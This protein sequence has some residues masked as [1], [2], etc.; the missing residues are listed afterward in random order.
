MNNAFV[1]KARLFAGAGV[2]ALSLAAF[3][4]PAYAQDA[5]DDS[6]QA[7]A[8][9][10]VQETPATAERDTIVVTGS[11]IRRDEYST[12]EPIT[13]VTA[14][15]ITQSG[16]NSA[17]DALQSAE[18]TAGSGQI[19]NY[20]AGFVT[21]G[22][23]GANTL[24]LRGLGPARTLV[25][26]NGRRLAPA[27][28][29]GAV[30][31]ADL[32]VLPTAIVERIE[33]LKAGASSVYGSDAIAGVVNII[34]DQEVRGLTLD[35]Q[36]NV[37]E[38]GSG[39]DRRISATFGLGTDRLNLIGSLEYRKRN[40][41]RLADADFTQ[42]PIP[43]NIDGEGAPLGSADPYPLGDPRNCFTIDNGGVTI[44]TIGTGS[45]SGI[46][47]TSGALGTFNRFVPAPGQGG[48]ATP[49]YLGVG[50]YDRDSFDPASQQEYLITPVETYTGYLSGTYELDAL[51]NAEL[52]AE[53]LATRRKSEAPLYRQLS[54]DYPV[55]LVD[56]RCD[57]VSCSIDPA[58]PNPLVPE[59]L[60]NSILAFPNETTGVGFLGVRAFV[61]FGLTE[62]SQEV[63][64]VRAGGGIRGD[65][66]FPGW[67][68]DFYVGKS[69]TDGTYEI[70]SFLTDRIAN[71]FDVV[72]N[73]DGTISCASLATN[74]NCV[75]APPLNADTVGG[76]LPQTYRDY[77]LQNTVGT[78]KFRET[79][80]AFAV[81]GPLFALP[82]GDVQ[83]ALGAEYRKQRIDDTP[84]VN[85]IQGNLL[86]LTSSEPTRGTDS[87][88]EVF[89]ELFVPLLADRPFFENLNLNASA[90]Y[91][92]YKSYG[93][94][95]TFKIA[96]EWELFRGFGFRGSYGTSYRAP[97]LAEQFLGATSGFLG[98]GSDPCDSDNFPD[99]PADYT[100][101]DTI[102]AQNC[103]QIGIDVATFSQ[104]NS[105][106]TYSLGGAEF[107]LEAETSTNW[108]VGAVVQP[109]LPAAVGSLS[110]ALDYFDI[111]VEN[112]VAQ[113][114]AGN[115]LNRCYSDPAFDPDAGFCRLH[116]RD[117]SNRLTVNNGYVNLSTDIV[118]GFEFNG[119]FATEAL[120]GNRLVLN[121][122]VTKYTEQS[123]R[124]FED[125]FLTDANGTYVTPDWV[126]T[127]DATYDVGS[128][129]LRYGLTWIDGSSGTYE[130]FAYDEQTGTVDEDLAQLYRDNY[131]LEVPDYFLHNASVQFD[132]AEDFE[133]TIGVR[134]IFDKQPPRISAAVTTIGNAPLYS[135]FDYFGRQFFVNTT[136][137]F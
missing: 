64:Y 20:Y 37:P 29:R 99:D 38:V 41:I 84:D 119:R 109:Q 47:R 128:V 60:R 94:D 112:G 118:K 46:G 43:G 15:E 44:N 91:T 127:F 131:I 57:A 135:G 90:R 92:D 102:T 85:A 83:L 133:F 106:T 114:G 45:R 105:I 21:D 42:C 77:I 96:G 51:G 116:E 101:N 67:R 132:V 31:S 68:Y 73:A 82:G 55:Y 98:G 10:E 136:F 54:L 126:G 13:V 104:N 36:V 30:L 129:L 130:Y 40:G 100:P 70:E 23:T 71:S 16:F 79:T 14:D 65:F 61:G 3:T 1:S 17:G 19:N 32:N 12:I 123:S 74:P 117:A 53:V 125:E 63:D 110:L 62:S 9:E 88:R 121:A 111:K 66:V 76:R 72:Q 56:D 89:G 11:R 103:A 86:G 25:L 6:L 122:S 58:R 78:N 7:P 48:G 81:D 24:G 33:I 22:G 35:A 134:N 59:F 80:F 4:S 124:L 8:E 27:G 120:F 75:A 95:V 50:L 69:W 39:I 115:I 108:S 52:Y 97:A 34:A 26:L 107:G 137:S 28:T 113:L 2:A 49:G 5:E 93:S 87:V 18:V